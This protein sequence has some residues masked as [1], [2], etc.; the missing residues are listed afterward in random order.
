[1]PLYVLV[2]QQ[3]INSSSNILRLSVMI[4]LAGWVKACSSDP[5]GED[6][7]DL[8]IAGVVLSGFAHAYSHFALRR[9]QFVQGGPCS[10]HYRKIYLVGVA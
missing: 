3:C 2:D 8:T 7:L 6:P 4:R 5:V 10:S 9:L 1:M